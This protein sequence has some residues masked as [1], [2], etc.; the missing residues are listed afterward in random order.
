MQKQWDTQYKIP[1]EG[2]R[3][4]WVLKKDN[5]FKKKETFIDLTAYFFLKNGVKA[6]A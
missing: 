1:F 3:E 2:K 6:K 4:V 5:S